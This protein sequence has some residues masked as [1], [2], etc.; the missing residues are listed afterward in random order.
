MV[1][2]LF[3]VAKA[4]VYSVPMAPQTLW[5]APGFNHVKAQWA[6]VYRETL[7]IA[8]ANKR[9]NFAVHPSPEGT[10]LKWKLDYLQERGANLFKRKN[11]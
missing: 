7:S 6:N 2:L 9:T 8:E 11:Q 4:V 1:L 10:N 3:F 5:A